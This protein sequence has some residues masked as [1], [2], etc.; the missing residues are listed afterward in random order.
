MPLV[1]FALIMIEAEPLGIFQFALRKALLTHLL[2]GSH[3]TDN[4]PKDIL[5]LTTDRE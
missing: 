4:S 2:T 3:S 1:E 5:L